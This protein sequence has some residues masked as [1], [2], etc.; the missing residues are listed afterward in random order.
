MSAETLAVTQD[1]AWNGYARLSPEVVR[2]REF[3]KRADYIHGLLYQCDNRT[4]F[5]RQK[6]LLAAT[7]GSEF[8]YLT[9]HIIEREI[10]TAFQGTPMT[11]ERIVRNTTRSNFNLK[12]IID[13][14]GAA[15]RLQKVP[16][17]GEYPARKPTESVLQ[18]RLEKF[19]ARIENPYELITNDDLGAFQ[20]IPNDLALAARRTRDWYITNLLFDS[21]GPID[22]VWTGDGGQASVSNTALNA[23][24]LS[25]ALL[26]VA[27]YTDNS[28]GHD[29]PIMMVP[30]FLVVP[31]ALKHTADELTQAANLAVIA[32]GVDSSPATTRVSQLNSIMKY[33]L[34]VVVGHY[35]PHVV[36]TGSKGSTCWGLVAAPSDVPIAEFGTLA[37]TSGPEVFMKASN[38]M[39]IGGGV[40]PSG[41]SFETD[42]IEYKVRDCMGGS[43]V[44]YHAGWASNGQ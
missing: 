17:S 29:E 22:A 18:Y 42:T 28:S 2:S 14:R 36:T 19:G 9:G 37:G 13:Y 6:A 38:Q 10:V 24:N 44:R 5:E 7:G 20:S 25:A 41:A 30:R 34:E 1:N 8:P 26:A 43:R 23:A 11:M 32:T 3:Q 27:Q 33:G 31:P 39:R 16:Q 15:E 40:D 35:I 12:N 21:D 4:P